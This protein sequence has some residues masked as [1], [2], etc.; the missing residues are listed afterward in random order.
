MGCGLFGTSPGRPQAESVSTRSAIASIC[1]MLPIIAHCVGHW[2]TKVD[3]VGQ[4]AYSRFVAAKKP[5]TSRDRVSIR[6]PDE[7]YIEQ[8]EREAEAERR[9][10]SDY[11]RVLIDTHPKRPKRP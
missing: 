11:L 2:K 8:L 9:K 3:I 4:A 1:F 6:F 7:K 5:K 10:L